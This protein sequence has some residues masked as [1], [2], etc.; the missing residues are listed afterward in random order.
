MKRTLK[1]LREER[2]SAIDE[3]T[4]LVNVSET[5]DRNLTEEETKSFDAT[6][7]KVKEMDARIERMEKSLELAKNNMPVTH[8]TQNIATSDKDLRKYSIAEAARSA[9]NNN[10]DGIVKEM[11]QEAL[12]EDNG[13]I[14]RGVGVPAIALEKRT[15]FL[16]NGAAAEANSVE[17]A[18]FIDQVTAA[19]VLA[20]AG[21][22]VYT[23]L[24]ANRKLPIIADIAAEY[25][26]EDGTNA[27]AGAGATAAGSVTA[28]TLSPKKLVSLVTYTQEMLV[29]NS[30]ID[31][32][33]ERNMA[34]VIASQMEKNLLALSD[35][36]KG[37]ESIFLDCTEG[38]STTASANLSATALFDLETSVLG[39]SVSSDRMAYICNSNALAAIK[40]L[41][42]ENFVTQFLDNSQRTV[43]GYPY[44]VT[45][46]LGA[47]GDANDEFILFGAMNDIHLGFF[48]GL[49]LV[50]DRFSEAHKGLSRLVVISMNDGL[51]AR[52]TTHFKR[53]I[54]V[55]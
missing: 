38:S 10:I 36:D 17:A 13:R 39:N 37:P 49:D 47:G 55:N 42:G 25:L 6:E 8:A 51:V 19:S 24:S 31:A 3:M 46:N 40:A 44:Y 33:L 16:A 15:N 45:S 23:G 21:A 30:S 34:N 52:P 7:A 5:E 53:F 48:G 32:A 43:N 11:H 28:K 9:M 26:D 35:Q 20:Q 14:F 41:A 22:N 29:Q 50:A 27:S 54:D 1:S 12:N 4:A 18:S 2:Q